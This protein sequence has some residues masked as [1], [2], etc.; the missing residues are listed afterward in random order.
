VPILAAKHTFLKHGILACSALHLAFLN[1]PNRQPYQLIAAHYQSIALPRFRS[2]IMNPNIDNCFALLAFTQLL[3]IHYFAADQYDEDLLLVKGKDDLLPDWLQVIRSSCQIFQAVW[4]RIESVPFMALVMG[5]IE[6]ERHDPGPGKLEHD[7]RL[8]GLVDMMKCSMARST[9]KAR[10]CQSSPL[11]S[12]LLILT[13]A[14]A[15]AEAD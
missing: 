1:P 15:K 3:I 10:D 2:E 12:A 5:G 13:R 4:P 11:P 14:F 9:Q 6:R 7:E 8:G